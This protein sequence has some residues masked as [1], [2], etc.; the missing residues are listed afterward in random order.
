MLTDSIN[1]TQTN[2]LPSPP[3][4]STEKGEKYLTQLIDLI[5]QGKVEVSRTDLSKFDITSLQDHYFINLKDYEVEI[6]HSKQPDSG[7]D[8]YVMLFN[9]LK[10]VK[11]NSESCTNKIIL[12]YIHLTEEQF[13]KFKD[14][15]GS[16]LE[17]KKQEEEKQRFQEAMAPIDQALDQIS[18]TDQPQ[19]DTDQQAG[20]IQTEPTPSENPIPEEPSKEEATP[21]ENSTPTQNIQVTV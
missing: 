8:F 10:V 6:S 3:L 14:T 20:L 18:T 13:N 21:A 5:N 9:N 4:G 12:A 1:P 16:Y 15:A 7:K 11:E 17:K 2:T 19:P